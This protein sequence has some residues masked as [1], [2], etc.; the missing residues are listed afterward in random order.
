M[1]RPPRHALVAAGAVT[2]TLALV[3]VLTGGLVGI[4]RLWPVLL[5]AAVGLAPGVAP[6]RLAALALGAV[7]GWGGV[8]LHLTALPDT[9]LG[10][11]AAGAAVLAVMIT[12]SV[13]SRDRLPL[14]AALVGAA[15]FL[16]V[17]EATS[18]VGPTGFPGDRLD[19]LGGLLIGLGT[20]ALA[21]VGARAVVERRHGAEAAGGE[22]AHDEH[23]PGG[24][25]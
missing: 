22:P 9:A 23:G 18:G 11:A 3:V 16:A 10:R 14:W 1:T 21:A 7:A 24:G 20:G 19:T 2:G 6:G 13:A 8:W 12:V 17:T 5:G 15:A 4:E 25:R